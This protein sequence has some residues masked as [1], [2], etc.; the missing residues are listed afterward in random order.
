VKRQKIKQHAIAYLIIDKFMSREAYDAKDLS[1]ELGFNV[2]TINKHLREL[3]LLDL[4]YICNWDRSNHE[5]QEAHQPTPVYRWGNKPDV[6]RPE[7]EN[8]SEISRRYRER[9]KSVRLN[10]QPVSLQSGQH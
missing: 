1:H 3:Y 6:K 2:I 5:K 4:I 8:K 7:P 10:Q 9:I